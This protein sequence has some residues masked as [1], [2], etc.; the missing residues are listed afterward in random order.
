MHAA[1]IMDVPGD[2]ARA[3]C[4][5]DPTQVRHRQAWTTGGQQASN[6]QAAAPVAAVAGDIQYG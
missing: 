3:V 2:H 6:V 5:N 1:D 4:G